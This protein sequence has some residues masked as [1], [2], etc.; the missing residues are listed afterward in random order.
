MK[1]NNFI[2]N[3]LQVIFTL[4]GIGLIAAGYFAKPGSTTDDGYP[5]DTFLY[6]LG[7]FFVIWPIVLFGAIRFFFNRAAKRRAWLVA[8]GIKGK[9][10][11]LKMEN[12]NIYINGVPQMVMDLQIITA[13]GERYQTTYKSVVPMQYYNIIRPDVD[14]PA[15]IDPTDKN[16]LFVDFQQ[17]WTDI[18]GKHSK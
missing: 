2:L 11:V 13:L 17:A 14:L 12:T 10:R 3:L 1:Y 4:V 8:N 6:M 16:K 5:L 9:A 7:I 15:F 18:A